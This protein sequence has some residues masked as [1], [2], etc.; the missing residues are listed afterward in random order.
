MQLFGVRAAADT[1]PIDKDSGNR[2]GSG[3]LGQSLLKPPAVVVLVQFD[4]F[5]TGSDLVEHV[6]GHFTVRTCGFREDHHTVLGYY[7]LDILNTG[8]GR[9]SRRSEVPHSYQRVDITRSN[10]AEQG[11]N[12]PA[13]D[14]LQ[15]LQAAAPSRENI[16]QKQQKESKESKRRRG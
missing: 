2:A 3:H 4:H 14:L 10:A 15:P 5:V 13:N 1:V 7:L 16:D 11:Q 8:R 6:F 12:D 9:S